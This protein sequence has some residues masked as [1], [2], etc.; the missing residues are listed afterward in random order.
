[1]INQ[2]HK[3][4]VLSS[5][6]VSIC[7][8]VSLPSRRK[9]QEYP[10]DGICTTVEWFGCFFLS[11]ICLHY[12]TSGERPDP[13]ISSVCNLHHQSGYNTSKKR[14]TEGERKASVFPPYF[15]SAPFSN[16]FLY[17]L[18]G[19]LHENRSKYKSSKLKKNIYGSEVYSI[20]MSQ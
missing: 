13:E 14:L 20:N 2:H 5:L 12:I 3:T 15:L 16:L 4:N 7:N 1:M 19:S 6:Q 8:S 11:S 10:G 18:F 9:E 17:F